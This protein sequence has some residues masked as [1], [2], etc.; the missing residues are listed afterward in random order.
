MKRA[1]FVTVTSALLSSGCGH[2][3]QKLNGTGSTFVAPII[4]KWSAAYEKA[5]GVKVNYESVGSSAG[6]ERWTA[7]TFDFAC[8]DAPLTERQLQE[9]KNKGG[10][11][12][13]IPLVLGAVVPAYNLPEVKEPLTF[14]G[15]VLADIY[16][17]SIKKWNDPALQQL[18]P[19]SALPDR[20]I[21]VVH[22][23]DGSGTSYI[24]TDYL[25]AV[26][27]QWKSK[28]GAGTSLTWPAGTGQI[29]N[30]G[31]ATQVKNA[32]GS[33]GYVQLDYALQKDIK[34][35]LVKNRE[36]VAIKATLESVAAA[37]NATLSNIPDDL[38][39]SIVDAAGSDSYPV[40][41]TSWAVLYVKQ[42]KGKGPRLVEFLRWATHEG[43]EQVG[44]L[45]YARLPKGLV[46]RLDK[47]LEQVTANQ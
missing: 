20:D 8:T 46:E 42:P 21:A 25:C 27:P 37:A 9:A 44:E 38:R 6:I 40:S 29:G 13:H 5:K 11:V 3:G 12:L 32:P 2:S 45:H 34:F 18:N 39:Y 1:L 41:G 7:G 22:R 24:W 33:I 31:V 26:S 4:S 14:S 16:L 35:G 43:Q 17:G 19:G 30:D 15:P 47:K 36:G 10:D 23:S 28:V